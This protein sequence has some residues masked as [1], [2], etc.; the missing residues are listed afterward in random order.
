M[1]GS[2]VDYPAEPMRA[3]SP[4][5]GFYQINAVHDM[6]IVYMEERGHVILF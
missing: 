6:H 5:K 2:A 3:T 4:R 1:A